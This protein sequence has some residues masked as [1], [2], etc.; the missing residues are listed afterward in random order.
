MKQDDVKTLL[1]GEVGKLPGGN[2]ATSRH[3]PRFRHPND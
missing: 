3:S 2:V 1:L